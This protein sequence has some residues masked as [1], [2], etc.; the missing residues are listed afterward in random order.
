MRYQL[1]SNTNSPQM[2]G[3]VFWINDTINST[4]TNYI[5]ALEVLFLNPAYNH[6]IDIVGY[7]VAEADS[8]AELKFSV[9]YLFL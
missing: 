8:I 5:E 4:K 1:L 3:G 7:I 9:P 6:N 2:E